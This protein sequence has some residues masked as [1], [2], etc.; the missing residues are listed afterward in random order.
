MQVAFVRNLPPERRAVVCHQQEVSG[1]NVITGPA[2]FVV[3]AE[4]GA[5]A[6][7]LLRDIERAQDRDGS[8]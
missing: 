6:R 2:E 8:L 5:R 4:D 7:E 3:R 1:D